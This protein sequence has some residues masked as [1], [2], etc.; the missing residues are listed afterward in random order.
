MLL[1]SGGIDSPV[2]GYAWPKEGLSYARTLSQLPLYGQLAKQKVIDLAKKLSAYC[3]NINYISRLYRYTICHQR[4]MPCCVHDYFMR[5]FMMRIAEKLALKT[6]C[7]AL[8]TGESGQ[9]ASQTMESINV[10]N[11]VVK[12]PVFRLD[13]L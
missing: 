11:S 10:T 6:G 12:L 7:S 13:R 5:R 8:I 9:V 4:K 3:G 1:L 2:A